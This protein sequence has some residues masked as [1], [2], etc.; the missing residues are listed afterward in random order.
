MSKLK[1]SISLILAGL[2]AGALL[3]LYSYCS[4][5]K[6]GAAQTHAV[7]LKKELH[8]LDEDKILIHHEVRA[9]DRDALRNRILEQSERLTQESRA[10]LKH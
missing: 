3:S 6:M 10:A 2:V 9:L 5:K 1:L 7:D 4:G 8:D